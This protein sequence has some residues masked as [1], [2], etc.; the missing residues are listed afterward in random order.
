MKMGIRVSGLF[1]VLILIFSIGNITVYAKEK[2]DKN[3]SVEI[4]YL[5][6]GD[7]IEIILE[8]YLASNRAATRK[9]SKTT[10]YKNSSGT[11]LWSVTVVG[12]FSYTS[13]K[14]AQCTSVSGSSVSY[15]S[16]W[17]VTGART[18]KN[19]NKASASATG[20]QIVNGVVISTLSRTVTLT[21]DSYGN[22]S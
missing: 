14:A 20:T 2:I 5:D 21:C 10:N 6:N 9:G 8:E 19:G 7:Y 12:T 22:L 18:S 11:T 17:K 16:A 3:V 1:L 15:S 4:E 13:G